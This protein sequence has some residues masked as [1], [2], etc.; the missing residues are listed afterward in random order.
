MEHNAT[1][2]G[3]QHSEVTK[4]ETLNKNRDLEAM[5]VNYRDEKMNGKD[6]IHNAKKIGRIQ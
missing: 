1:K 6:N 2:N 4:Y 3:P 5:G